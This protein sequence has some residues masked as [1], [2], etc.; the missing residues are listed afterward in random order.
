MEKLLL[1][2]FAVL[3]DIEAFHLLFLGNPQRQ[4][5]LTSLSRA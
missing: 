1:Q 5:A 2:R 4:K 3:C